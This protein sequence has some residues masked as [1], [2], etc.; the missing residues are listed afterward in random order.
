MLGLP[1]GIVRLEPYSPEWQRYY[2]HE[3]ILLEA[4]LGDSILDIQ[5]VGS[6]AI[7]GMIAKPIID[8]DVTVENYE[9][10]GKCI[11][12]IEKVGYMYKGDNG[13]PCSY[14]FV[15]GIPA[16]YHLH[17][18]ET[19]SLP[20]QNQIYF[21]DYLIENPGEARRYAELKV[22]LAALYPQN[23]PAYLAG[24]ASFIERIMEK[25][26]DMHKA[27]QSA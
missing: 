5:H 10:A 4:A 20:W 2:E 19:G 13:I 14:Y 9:D 18:Y 1:D 23:R 3:K 8:I 25:V 17:L 26:R 27:E 22:A 7:E 11:V 21:R 24:K 15:K 6:T 12:P 16:Q